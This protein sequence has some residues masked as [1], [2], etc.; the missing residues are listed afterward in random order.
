V[1][2]RLNQQVPCLDTRSLSGASR[3]NTVCPQAAQGL[4]PRNPVDWRL[5]GGLLRQI[6]AREHHRRHGKKC[7]EDNRDPNLKGLLH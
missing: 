4:K 7:Q 6:D 1:P 3:E 2:V 5:F